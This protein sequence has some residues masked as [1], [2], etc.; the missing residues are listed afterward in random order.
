VRIENRCR[1]VKKPVSR[2]ETTYTTEYDYVTKSSRT[3][4]HTRYISEWEF[5]TECGLEPVPHPVVTTEVQ[6]QCGFEPVTRSVTSPESQVQS[7]VVPPRLDE[8][9]KKKVTQSQP[10]CYALPAGEART[11]NRIEAKV[12]MRP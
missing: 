9:Q 3:I 10:A 5:K 11:G 8:V 7:Q 4:P 6:N 2:Y 12:Y 1:E